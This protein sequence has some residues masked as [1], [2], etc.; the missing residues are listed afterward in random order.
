MM[1]HAFRNLSLARKVALI[2][3]L[4]VL[5]MGIMF[6][7]AIHTSWRNTET[8]QSLDRSVF[9][10]LNRA[11]IFKDG[12]TLLHTRLFALL[13]VGANETNPAAQKA[14]A[15]ALAS[16]LQVQT[17]NF[18]RLL[19][20]DAVLGAED[21]AGIRDAFIAYAVRLQ[22]TADF[23]SYD[24]SY[25]ALAARGAGDLFDHLR[26]Q[27]DK[28]VQD[29]STRRTVLVSDAFAQTVGTRHL[30]ATLALGAALLA[31]LGSALVGRGI[32]LPLVALTARMQRLAGGDT[33]VDV[34]DAD[35]RDE[36]GAM[37]RA[38]KVFRDNAIARREGEEA[39][40]RTNIQFDAALSS[41]LQ[42]M[43]VWGP[44][45][46]IRLINARCS[47]ITG[48]P[49]GEVRAGMS[50]EEM[51]AACRA[52]G[53]YP[54]QDFDALCARQNAVL[55]SRQS[56]Q[57]ETTMRPGLLIKVSYEPM[58]DGGCVMTFEDITEKRQNEEQIVHMAHHDALTGLPNRTMFHERME[59]EVAAHIDQDVDLAVL[60]LDLDHFKEVNDTLGHAV[61]DGLLR[62]VTERL[63]LC[64]RSHDLVARLGGD[65]FAVL[66]TSVEGRLAASS[67][68]ARIIERVSAPYE[69]EGHNIVIGASIGIALANATA[70]GFELL[71][72]A[73]MALYRAKEERGTFFFFE[74]GMDEHLHARRGLEADLRSALHLGEF[75]M[76]YQPL[77]NLVRNHVTGFEALLRWQSPTRGMVSPADFIPLA[78]QTGLI[79][80][81]GEWV[82]RTACAEAVRWPDDV[83]VAVNL[84]P[85]QFKSKRLVEMVEDALKDTGL[86][87]HRLE[88]EITETVLLQESE[89]VMAMLNRLHDIGV[90]ISMDDFG[91]GYSS[92]SYLRRFPFDKI[93]IDRSFVTDLRTLS[94]DDVWLGASGQAEPSADS[95][96]VI[97]RAIAGLGENLG[98]ATT[99][100]GVET[101]NQLLQLR[102]ERCTEVQGY[103]IS[104]PRPA[105]EVPGLLARLNATMPDGR[106]VPAPGTK[107]A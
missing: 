64:V 32:A 45:L 98:I 66:L 12:I 71:K 26:R 52:A 89:G 72:Q 3:A 50:V 22:E 78:E 67:L 80:P 70:E 106:I 36:V 101:A 41:M 55:T 74:S 56:I 20:M 31:L 99:A 73:D 18:E 14:G 34:P 11:Q 7:A 90:R 51:Y 38:V 46:R 69:V 1:S 100:E 86:A 92:L 27:L 37:A 102:L 23:A 76:Y 97:V 19:E 59:K 43:I 79:I 77:F 25:G 24:S 68:A 104:P 60:C 58:A 29:L 42:G 96:S 88:L 57:R 95:A 4:T 30:V 75:E 84:S 103:F 105:S 65:E 28:L 2:P 6:A 44:D 83:K 53:L 49:A 39:L 9:E 63:R 48:L 15:E 85:V 82:L 87:P 93:K 94:Q 62:F 21:V 17:A 40:R 13:S 107:A 81:I 47:E 10:P 91:T 16:L 54:D 33:T 8:L 61:G 5:M 35:R